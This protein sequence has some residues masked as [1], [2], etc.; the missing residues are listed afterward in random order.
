MMR[1]DMRARMSRRQALGFGLRVL[2]TGGSLVLLGT[3]CQQQ[4]P[5][6]PAKPTEAAKPAAPAATTAPAAPAAAA[7]TQAAPAAAKPTEA[8]KPAAA[9]KPDTGNP[10]MAG[11]NETP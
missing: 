4:Q 2:A 9:A 3:A 11:A 6:A 7:P 10:A 1:T 5:A 8:A